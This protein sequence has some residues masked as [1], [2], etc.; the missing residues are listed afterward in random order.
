MQRDGHQALPH[1]EMWLPDD[2]VQEHGDR[3]LD[4]ML[5]L[6]AQQA[7]SFLATPG[8]QYLPRCLYLRPAQPRQ[9][10]ESAECTL[11]HLC[12]ALLLA[13]MEEKE[14]DCFPPGGHAPCTPLTDVQTGSPSVELQTATRRCGRQRP[15]V[16]SFFFGNVK[17][18][19]NP[20]TYKLSDRLWAPVMNE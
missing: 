20:C 6:V 10:S 7:A 11:R 14:R 13:A 17:P 5:L 18:L 4:K 19:E 9:A 12:L 2:T 1:Q 8:V 3:V 15:M 16:L